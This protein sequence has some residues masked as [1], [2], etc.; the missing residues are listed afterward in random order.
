MLTQY[1]RLENVA[2]RVNADI[3]VWEVTD[4][5]SSGGTRRTGIVCPQLTELK[6]R[7]AWEYR[8]LHGVEWWRDRAAQIV[9][10]RRNLSTVLHVY[11]AWD[12]GET[13][14]LLA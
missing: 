11:G 2:L 13:F 6:I 14:T 4:A 5:M 1:S 3:T 10:G 9:R 8:D 7:I 12:E